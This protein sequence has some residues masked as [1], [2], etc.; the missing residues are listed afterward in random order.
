MVTT[1]LIQQGIKVDL[2]QGDAR[3]VDAASQQH[4]WNIIIDAQQRLFL[5]DKEIELDTLMQELKQAATAQQVSAVIMH[6]DYA[7][8][9]GYVT[10]LMDKIKY[11][12]T[13]PYVG[14]ATQKT[15]STAKRSA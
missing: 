6:V 15:R 11:I 13:I 10:E 9:S 2:P 8:P 1:P 3:E 7:V 4:D 5:Q 12:G 14:L